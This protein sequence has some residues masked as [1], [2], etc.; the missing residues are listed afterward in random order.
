MKILIIAN[1]DIGLYKFRRELI[2]RLLETHEVHIC[3]PNG[4]Y[5]KELV[6]LGCVYHACEFDRHGTNPF[7]EVKLVAHYKKLV[8]MIAPGIV[9]TYTVKPNIYAG[10]ACASLNIPYVANITGLGTAIENG[11]VMQKILLPLC[12]IG[13]RKAQK[14]FFQNEENRDF[15]LSKGV[16]KGEYD[17][18]PGSGVNLREYKTS[19]YPSDETVRFAFISRIMKEKG[20]DQ[21]LDA[22]EY[23]RAKYPDTEFHVCGFCEQAYEER[24]RELHNKGIIHYHGMIRDV[25]AFLKEIHCTIHPTYYPEGLS[26]VLLESCASA[27]PIIT[28]NRSGCREVV[29]DAVNGYVVREKDSDDLIEK[30]EK[31]L[32]LSYEQKKDMGLRGREKVEREFDRNIVVEK[33]LKEISNCGRV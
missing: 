11:G 21:Y 28:T 18:L 23:I 1:N 31:F 8:R 27:R 16:I 25:K 19:E 9:F 22:A 3:L 24:L 20:I 7:T 5:V 13:L 10:I 29:D 14:V 15:M 6:K 32:L 4:E 33:Y 30:V 17:L 12:K 26:N 2:E